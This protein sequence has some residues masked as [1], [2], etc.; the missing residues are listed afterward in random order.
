MVGQIRPGTVDG[1]KNL[2][3]TLRVAIKVKTKT[4]HGG[5]ETRRNPRPV[6]HELTRIN[7]NK[8]TENQIL[9]RVHLGSFM[10]NLYD[11]L[12]VSVPPWWVLGF[13]NYKLELGVLEIRNSP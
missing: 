4:H 6:S 11:F 7:T 10:A 9:I 8:K 2:F 12:S 3:P 5:T 13:G 1:R